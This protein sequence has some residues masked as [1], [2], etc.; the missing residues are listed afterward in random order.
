MEKS[1]LNA[2]EELEKVF[3]QKLINTNEKLLEMEKN[4]FK[5]KVKN[6]EELN[7]LDHLN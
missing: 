7:K 4:Y 2:V 3:E 6:K 1:H 5:E